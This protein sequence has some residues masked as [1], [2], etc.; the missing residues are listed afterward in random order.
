[1]AS[2]HHI[3]VVAAVSAPAELQYDASVL[4]ELHSLHC[5]REKGHFKLTESISIGI[6]NQAWAKIGR[7]PP[8]TFAVN[9]S[10]FR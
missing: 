4:V 10:S 7:S 8:L 6:L 3:R 1:M 5:S 9:Q 2:V